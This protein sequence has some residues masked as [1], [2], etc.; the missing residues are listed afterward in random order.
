M[1]SSK[2]KKTA[3]WALAILTLINVAILASIA[4]H[5]IFFKPPLPLSEKEMQ[6]KQFFKHCPTSC[7][8][9]TLIKYH[10]FRKKYKNM[11]MPLVDS[12]REI[13]YAIMDELQKDTPDTIY[14]NTLAD[15]SGLLYSKLRKTTVKEFLQMR[16]SF[17]QDLRMDF[18]HSCGR[19]HRGKDPCNFKGKR[20]HDVSH[21]RIGRCKRQ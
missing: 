7:D 13:R 17:P 11:S 21:F 16:D 12:M 8:S 5:L 1:T 14:L 19:G 15:K 18:L 2:I 4:Y 3:L 6:G 9:L 20:K 10:N